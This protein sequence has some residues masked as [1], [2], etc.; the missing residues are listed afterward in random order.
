M[1]FVGSTI[2]TVSLIAAAIA[3][4]AKPA[5]AQ[6]APKAA[7]KKIAVV[8]KHMTGSLVSLDAQKQTLV[9]KLKSADYTFQANASTKISNGST[10][11]AFTALKTGVSVSVDYLRDVSG[12]TAI[13]IIQNVPVKA[14][15]PAKT[16]QVAP[17]APAPAKVAQPAPTAA[18]AKVA[19]PA[20]AP[21][22]AATPA[23]AVNA[24]PA[25]AKAAQPAPA[26]AAAP[27]AAKQA[28][29]AP[30]QAVAPANT[31]APAKAAEPAPVAATPAK[32]APAPAANQAPANSAAPAP[33]KAAEPAK[34]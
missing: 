9:V 32:V 28:Q 30:V 23:P 3:Q 33:V 8:Q 20:P 18:P 11:I 14:A 34:K 13:S 2:L 12:R 15:A 27:V 22:Q 5:A 21:A 16:A 1:K 25:P 4:P 24:V 26:P 7:E 31:A 6:E 17:A 19:T 29:P 10:D